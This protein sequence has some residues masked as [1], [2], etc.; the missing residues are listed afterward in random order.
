MSQ[1]LYDR[2]RQWIDDLLSLV[3]ERGDTQTKT[4]DRAS[5]DRTA[6]EKEIKSSRQ[7][8]K[9]RRDRALQNAETELQRAQRAAKERYDADIKAN[10]DELGKSRLRLTGEMDVTEEKL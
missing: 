8:L 7:A 1:L 5:N 2:Q 4:E 6:A 9:S 3:R 10:D